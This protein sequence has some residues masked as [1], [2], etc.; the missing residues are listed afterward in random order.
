MSCYLCKV[1]I[2][3][4]I[5]YEDDKWII[6]DCQEYMTPFVVLREH[7]TTIDSQ[8]LI[9]IL[10]ICQRLFGEVKLNINGGLI[11]DHLYFHLI[12]KKEGWCKNVSTY[13]LSR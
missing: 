8:S 3:S 5:Y 7:T 4:H 6:Y 11:K 12:I 10:Q 13:N 1:P 2:T 9:F